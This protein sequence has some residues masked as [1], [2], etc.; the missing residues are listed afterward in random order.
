MAGD[1]EYS[2]IRED[3]VEGIVDRLNDYLVTNVPRSEAR[4]DE[5]D[6]CQSSL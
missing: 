3:F 2:R 5:R 6:D 1:P 4:V